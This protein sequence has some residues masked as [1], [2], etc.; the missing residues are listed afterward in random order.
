MSAAVRTLVAL[1]LV[2]VG[3]FTT[4]APARAASL[5]APPSM[6][7]AGPGVMSRTQV[8][9]VPE[10]GLEALAAELAPTT[11][12][13]LARIAQD[14][15]GLPELES[16]E[17]R[18][19]KHAERMSEFAPPGHGAPIWAAGVAYPSAGVILVAARGADGQF[20]DAQ[21]TLVHE[22]AHMALDRALAGAHVPRW[23]HEG[24][25]Y[26]HS[27]EW[28]WGRTQTLAGALF[29][30]DLIPVGALE[31]A[32]P[33]RH[34]AVSLA[35]AES[36]DFVEFLANRGRWQDVADD[37]NPAALRAFLAALPKTGSVDLA[38]AESYG[39]SLAQLEEEWTESLRARYMWY[40]AAAI[41]GLFWVVLALL[42][43]VGYFRKRRQ[44]RARL[45]D[46][47]V[48]ERLAEERA[49]A[50]RAAE[51]ARLRAEAA[52]H[53]GDGQG[54]QLWN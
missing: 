50:E 40:P 25:A 34:D 45:A 31:Y 5:D 18:L 28:S 33:E 22:L 21:G 27:T 39:R 54:A 9:F 11:Q 30:G 20:L 1:W 37:G 17:V 47:A 19:V 41:A 44:L 2:L 48:E 23:L 29:S 38:L 10:P 51:E 43:V 3:V 46:M 35:Y 52:L 6:R 13:A 16:V 14:L 15:P 26:R 8:R 12:A 36:Y 7:A 32:F 24:F 42:A 4:A 53:G 49:A